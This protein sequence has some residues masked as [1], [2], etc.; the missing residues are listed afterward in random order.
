[1]V[2]LLLTAYVLLP[3][4]FVYAKDYKLSKYTMIVTHEVSAARESIS[5]AKKSQQ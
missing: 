5:V 2:R 3:Y 4:V 1:L